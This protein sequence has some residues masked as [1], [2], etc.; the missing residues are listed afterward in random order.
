M[1]KWAS[2]FQTLTS[3]AM[4]FEPYIKVTILGPFLVIF[5]RLHVYILQKLGSDGHLKVSNISKT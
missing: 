4:K 3:D 5:C 2:F 1:E